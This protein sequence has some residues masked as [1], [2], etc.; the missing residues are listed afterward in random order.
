METFTGEIMRDLLASS[1][2]T[3][4]IDENGWRDTGKG[5]GSRAS[6]Y[7]DWLTIRDQAESVRADLKRTKEHPLVPDSIPVH[8]YIYDCKTGRLSE[9]PS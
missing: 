1:L 7:I 9:V 6:D 5:P 4:S 3:A 2:D 8:G